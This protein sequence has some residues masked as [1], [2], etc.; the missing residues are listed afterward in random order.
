MNFKE[1]ELSQ[2]A[3]IAELVLQLGYGMLGWLRYDYWKGQEI[4]FFCHNVQTSFGAHP[5]IYTVG[6]RGCLLGS[7]AIGL[8][9]TTRLHLVPRL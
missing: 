3:G 9:L 8:K 4:F 1:S 6:T 7:K 5:V 2:G